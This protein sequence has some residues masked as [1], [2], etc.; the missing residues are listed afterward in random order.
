MLILTLTIAAIIGLSLGLIG[1]GGGILT[2]PALVYL[3]G[4][5]PVAATGYSLF[6]VGATSFYG[7]SVSLLKKQADLRTALLFAAPGM[8]TAFLAR[9]ILLPLLPETWL[10]IG[11]WVLTREKGIMLLFAVLM[12]AAG[13]AMIRPFGLLAKLCTRCPQMVVAGAVVGLIAGIT[14]AG[15]GFL[16][17]PALV[18]LGG[19]PMKMA[20]HTS[21]VIVAANSAIAFAGDLGHAPTPDWSFLLAFTGLSIA[22]M[23]AGKKLSAYWSGAGLRK[24][25]GWFVIILGLFITI[26]E[27]IT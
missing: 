9:S 5:S 6:I 25:F 4:I 1:A 22:G 7:G 2:V 3:M 17:I 11:D 14:G 23:I 26:K 12:M 27:V 21:L 16:I 15:G 18:L 24:S 10:H 8:V 13:R 20:V 19:M